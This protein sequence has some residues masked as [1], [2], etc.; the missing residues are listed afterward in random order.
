MAKRTYVSNKRTE[1]VA[2]HARWR[3]HRAR[4]RPK[5]PTRPPSPFQ[6]TL[7]GSDRTG[8]RT[9]R[10]AQDG[11]GASRLLLGICYI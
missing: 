11:M 5:F 6:F 1:H 2:T 8:E 7:S 10:R 9:G 3:R 4:R